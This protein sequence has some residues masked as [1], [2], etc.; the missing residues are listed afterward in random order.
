MKRVLI[1]LVVIAAISLIWLAVSDFNNISLNPKVRAER[2]S[3]IVYAKP[4][5][6]G[7]FV[8]QEIWKDTR[9]SHSP[10]IGLNL[11]KLKNEPNVQHPDGVVSFYE[12]SF[13]FS[14][15]LTERYSAFVNS[16]RVDE[17]TL[18]EYKKACGLNNS[19][20]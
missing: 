18:E 7:A 8:V 15:H 17:M 4:D 11:F 5:T 9:K 10:V 12:K 2:S 14:Q 16:G 20:P 6:N 19:L 3:L 1:G 13:W